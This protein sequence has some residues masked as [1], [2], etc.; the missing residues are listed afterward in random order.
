MTDPFWQTKKLN[1]MSRE[2]W[3][4]LCDGCGKCCLLK[5]EDDE[6]GEIAYTDV[7]C[8]LFDG[9]TCTCTDYPNRT[10]R[11]P[12]CIAL[13][14]KNIQEIEWM[15]PTCAYRLL[16]DGK[17]L[18]DW[19]PL[20]SGERASVHRAGMSVRGRV[21]REGE[22]ADDDLEDRIVVWPEAEPID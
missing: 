15:P 9:E 16:A 21:L 20:V 12:D 7:I 19:H 1:E 10:R 4:S 18:Y 8:K 22:V 11:V 2:E 17:E 3:E 6:T 13:T 14:P 5:L